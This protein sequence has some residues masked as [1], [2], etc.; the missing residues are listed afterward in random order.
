MN[1]LGKNRTPFLFIIDFE[2]RWPLVVELQKASSS[3]I[4]FDLNGKRNY[5]T[6]EFI[7][8]KVSFAKRPVSFSHFKKKFDEIQRQ[9][10]AGNTYLL[11]LTFPTSIDINLTLDEIF[12]RSEAKYKLLVKDRFV[13]FSPETFVKISPG[14]LISSYPMKGTIDAAVENAEEEILNNFK[15]T[16]EHNTIVDLIRNDLNSVAKNVN[17]EKF[18]YL[19]SVKT[20]EKELL[21]V[22]SKITGILP[23]DYPSRIGAILFSML[24]AGSI[25]GAPKRKTVEIILKNERYRRGYYT[26]IAGWF[27]GSE[28]ESTVLI[29][30][31]EKT[32]R[33]FVFKSGGGITHFSQAELEY[34]EM[35]DKVYV[36]ITRNYQG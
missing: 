15:E 24:P 28:L 3:V 21:Q 11:N 31:I 8:D 25:C 6:N 14:G 1:E 16:A 17:V 36:P 26:G 34:Q 22:S 23:P 20:H 12:L 27:D 5:T 4:L 32:R 7:P 35:I 10:K 30:F 33:G 2:M 9:I 19:E 18:R 29:R 13:C